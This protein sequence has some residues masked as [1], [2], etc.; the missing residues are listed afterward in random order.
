MAGRLACR[1]CGRE[2]PVLNG[3]PAL[4]ADEELGYG[5]V[6]PER[7][8]AFLAMKSRAY[9]GCSV[10]SRLYN[11]YHR[12]AARRRHLCGQAPLTVDVGF[13][14]GEHAP[15]VS[16]EEKGAGSFIGIDLDRR[17]LEHYRTG[18]GEIPV[19][20]ASACRLPFA[21]GS[22]DVVQLLAVLEHFP[23]ERLGEVVA[24]AVRVL[25]TGGVMIACYPAEGGRLLRL[26]QRIMHA[27]LRRRTGFDLD[28]ELVHHHQVPAVAVRQLLAGRRELRN[29]DSLF[30]PLG[31]KRIDFALFLNETYRR[32]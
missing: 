4:V 10:I 18:H 23:P 21:D 12:Y 2:F 17:K 25:R 3:I 26:S 16:D 27:Y 28:G 13:G 24:E 20:Q 1:G 14:I 32:V 5:E 9:G 11:H 8:D 15:F 19:L 29:V 7:W 30:Y 31:L 6:A 22:V